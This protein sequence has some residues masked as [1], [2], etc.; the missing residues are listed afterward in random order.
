MNEERLASA[1]GAGRT[2]SKPATN[3]MYDAALTA[4]AGEVPKPA[5]TA[6]A[7]TGPIARARL[8]V[9]EFSA[10]ACG[11]SSRGTSD[12]IIAIWAA[13]VNAFNDPRH[14]EKRMSARAVAWPVQ[15][16]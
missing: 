12:P 2:T 15:A 6:A 10:T 16:T 5:I 7:L 11:R 13:F 9:I 14:N 1:W 8:N 3:R 4:N